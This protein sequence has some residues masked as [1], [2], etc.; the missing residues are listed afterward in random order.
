MLTLWDVFKRENIRV[1]YP[2]REI[3]VRDGALPVETK[4]EVSS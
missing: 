3:R 2:V 4:V 1:P